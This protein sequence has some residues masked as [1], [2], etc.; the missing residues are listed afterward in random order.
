MP[1]I[2]TEFAFQHDKATAYALAPEHGL[3]ASL[4]KQ[5]LSG[6]LS[7]VLYFVILVPVMIIA[8]SALQLDA[9]TKPASEMLGKIMSSLPSITGA[10]I[11]LL[12]A[13]VIGKVVSGIVTTHFETGIDAMGV[14][15][16]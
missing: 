9:I 8:L 7:L 16:R 2:T 3:A 4:G 15:G 6:V 12:L 11:V 14:L 13:V 5:K 1:T 10:A